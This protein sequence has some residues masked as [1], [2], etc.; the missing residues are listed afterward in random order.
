MTVIIRFN[1]RAPYWE[2][3]VLA[4]I[5]DHNTGLREL[6]LDEL[7]TEG[8]PQEQSETEVF[9]RFHGLRILV[10]TCVLGFPINK[11]PFNWSD[12]HRRKR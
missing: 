4:N 7:V 12:V 9:P 2:F 5:A 6:C 11:T 3:G 10:G 8:K 1:R